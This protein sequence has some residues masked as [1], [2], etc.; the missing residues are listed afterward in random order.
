MDDDGRHVMDDAAMVKATGKALAEWSAILDGRGAPS[1]THTEIARLLHE[2][3]HV[4]GWWSQM[5]TVEYERKIGRRETGQLAN[6]EFRTMVSKTLTGTMEEALDRWLAALP[7]GANA[8]FDGVLFASEPSV[9]LRGKR[10][11]WRVML[12]DGAK[13]TVF[14]SAKPGGAATRGEAAL[15]AVETGKLGGTADIE[16]WKAYWKAYVARL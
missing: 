6:G 14:I 3:Y 16:R 4:P 2:D 15:L 7:A 12:A 13:V 8:G 10:Y 9:S 1:L 11:A 5:V